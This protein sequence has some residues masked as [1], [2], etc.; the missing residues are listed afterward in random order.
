MAAHDRIRLIDQLREGPARGGAFLFSGPVTRRRPLRNRSAV[1]R[2][3]LPEEPEDGHDDQHRS[4]YC[5]HPARPR[6]SARRV[7]HE[8]D[9]HPDPEE[10]HHQ[11]DGDPARVRRGR[12]GGEPLIPFRAPA[13]HAHEVPNRS[14]EQPPG[15]QPPEPHDFQPEHRLTDRKWQPATPPKR[16]RQLHCGYQQKNLA[17]PVF[18]PLPPLISRLRRRMPSGALPQVLQ[19]AS[20]SAT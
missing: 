10:Q 2:P 3:Q 17:A 7:A 8:P 15:P 9:R 19:Y 1:A 20:T 5:A 18:P 4:Q 14:R 11:V 16:L 6:S 13:L 12:S